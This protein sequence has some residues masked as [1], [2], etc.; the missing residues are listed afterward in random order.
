MLAGT[1]TAYERASIGGALSGNAEYFVVVRDLR[2]GRILHY[3][4]TGESISPLP[5]IVGDGPVIAIVVKSDGAVAWT[6]D[7]EESGGNS[8]HVHA[9]D[10]NG[11]RVLAS[12]ADI[13]PHSLAL[14]GS[15]LYW[16]QG[17][18]PFSTTLN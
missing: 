14:A 6:V 15:T 5:G 8:Y 1:I 12:G 9:L 11:Q 17:G 18:K 10:K 2:T 16:A 3:V 13:D 7:T 4:P